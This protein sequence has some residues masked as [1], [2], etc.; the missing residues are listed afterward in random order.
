MRVQYKTDNVSHVWL[1]LLYNNK[2]IKQIR[3]KKQITLLP[4]EANKQQ[5]VEQY[6]KKK[7][8]NNWPAGW[9]DDDPSRSH[10]SIQY[11]Y[12]YTYY[13]GSNIRLLFRILYTWARLF[14]PIYFIYTHVLYH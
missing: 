6:N 14:H 7:K 11:V 10:R 13:A 1:L 4:I 9:S 2:H 12:G 3:I 5:S 8:N